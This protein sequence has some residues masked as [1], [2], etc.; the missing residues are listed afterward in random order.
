[1][2]RD[3]K[4]KSGKPIALPP[5]KNLEAHRFNGGGGGVESSCRK[6]GSAGRQSVNCYGTVSS[7]SLRH[8][9]GEGD[10][11]PKSE[12]WRGLITDGVDPSTTSCAGGPPPHR[13]ATGRS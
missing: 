11:S 2:S 3:P 1:M 4:L 5:E 6:G 13:F 9:R 10:H 8:R 7:S 12:W